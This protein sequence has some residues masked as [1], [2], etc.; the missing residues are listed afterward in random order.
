MDTPS[1]PE[2]R[3][4]VKAE[5]VRWGDIVKKAGIAGSQ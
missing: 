5:V 3:T 1:V 2:M 4:F